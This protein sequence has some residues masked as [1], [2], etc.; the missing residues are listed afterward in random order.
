MTTSTHSHKRWTDKGGHVKGV[1]IPSSHKDVI[2][3]ML[4]DLVSRL[5]LRV[6]EAF[7]LRSEDYWG[8]H[9]P[10]EILCVSGGLLEE[11]GPPFWGLSDSA[12]VGETTNELI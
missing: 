2:A 9:W 10:E 4:V 6:G 7:H 12:W 3:E 5:S 11:V 8:P 1:V